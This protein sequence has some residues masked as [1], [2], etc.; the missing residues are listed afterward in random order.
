M[1]Q[2]TTTHRQKKAALLKLK[3][4]EETMAQLEHKDFSQ[5]HVLEI[6]KQTKISKVTFFRYF[7]QKED[8]LLY[9]LR[10]WLL[11]L[12]VNSAKQPKK[13]KAAIVNLFNNLTRFCDKY[14]SLFPH[15]LKHYAEADVAIKPI[16]IKPAEKELRFPEVKDINSYE[17]LSIDRLLERHLL[18]AVF[19][20]EINKS[21]NVDE[22]VRLFQSML[23]G[24]ILVSKLKNFPLSQLIKRNVDITMEMLH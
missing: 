23:Y 18:E 17:L 13:G 1:Q 16:N 14:P 19:H 8:I 24:S 11:E 6:C 20:K 5:I 10:M 4:M 15:I 7:P 12:M 22:M 21:S 2:K 9:I 3:I